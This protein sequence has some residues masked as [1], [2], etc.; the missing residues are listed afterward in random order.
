MKKQLISQILDEY[1]TKSPQGLFLLSM[2][3]GFGKTH[4][5]LDFIYRNYRD[6]ANQG[7]KIFFVTNLKK[8][9]PS[10]NLEERFQ[11]EGYQ[12]DFAKYVLSIDSNADSVI[13]NLL[14]IGN[15]IPERY[16]Q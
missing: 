15:E 9:L 2:P 13:E 12:D 7:R 3:T 6:F 16:T 8:N 1:C 5:V 10:R 11:K 4:N 14:L